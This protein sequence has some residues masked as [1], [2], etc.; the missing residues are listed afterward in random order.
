M[1]DFRTPLAV[2]ATHFHQ[3]AGEDRLFQE[4]PG[5]G[6]TGSQHQGR[7]SPEGVL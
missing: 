4:H 1:K 2:L 7:T 3:V 5:V 6:L